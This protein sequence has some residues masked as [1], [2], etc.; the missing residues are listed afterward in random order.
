MLPGEVS[1]EDRSMRRE[2]HIHAGDLYAAKDPASIHTL[3]GSCVA[4]CLYDPAERLGGMNHILLPGRADMKHFDSAARY[5]VNAMELLINRLMSLGGNR[6]RF[7]AKAF[8]G[9]HVLA[10]ISQENGTG[11]RNV[12][13]VLEF[14]AIEGIPLAGYDLGGCQARR[15]YF[16]TDTGDAWVKRISRRLH[17]RVGIDERKLYESVRQSAGRSSQVTLFTKE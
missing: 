15:V 13:F 6:R 2:I 14:L 7:V 9:A 1:F 10:E 3:L 17:A 4:V 16:D 5:G 11:Q 8:G 12:E